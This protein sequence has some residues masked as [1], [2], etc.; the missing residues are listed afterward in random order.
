M[1]RATNINISDI[2]VSLHFNPRPREEGDITT[3]VFLITPTY[4]N[5]R[6]RE[7]GDY[8]VHDRFLYYKISIHALVKRA[9]SVDVDISDSEV[10]SIH[11]LVKRA[12]VIISYDQPNISNFNPRPREEGDSPLLNISAI[13][14]AI[15]IHAL[16][17]RA[18]TYI[19]HTTHEDGISI[20]A[21]VKRA[22]TK[23]LDVLLQKW[24]SIHALVKRATQNSSKKSTASRH[25]N[26][27][28]REEGDFIALQLR[29]KPPL[30]QSTPS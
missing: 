9:T 5:P 14:I 18:T 29:A 2:I 28:P 21:L 11:A 7:E 27:R 20:H 24:I 25:F 6:P 30:F 23:S 3:I 8:Q 1:K 19:E 22:T 26:P 16:V 10:I 15:S 12:T 17:K 13:A 4:F